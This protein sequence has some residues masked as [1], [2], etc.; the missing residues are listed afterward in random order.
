MA[1]VKWSNPI[2]ETIFG[3]QDL[4]AR[5]WDEIDWDLCGDVGV[6]VKV[7]G[8]TVTIRYGWKIRVKAF[9]M[10]IGRWYRGWRR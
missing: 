4:S 10:R 6:I 5:V 3:N 7:D 9:F 2:S 1:G 8:G